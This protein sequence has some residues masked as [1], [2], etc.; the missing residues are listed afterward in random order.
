MQACALAV[1]VTAQTQPAFHDVA[2][3]SSLAAGC[4][5]TQSSC[6]AG[7]NDPLRGPPALALDG[8][9]PVTVNEVLYCTHTNTG[10]GEWWQVDLGRR[11]SIGNVTIVGRTRQ[12]NQ[13]DNLQVLLKDCDH[14]ETTACGG[15]DARYGTF[16]LNFH[17]FD[18]FEL[19]L[20]GHTQPSGAALS[21]LRLKWADMVLI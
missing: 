5:A 7:C 18:R 14:C 17:R 3:S 20:R 10:V 9:V 13:G 1:I 11:R 6:F 16:R 4:T 21:C 19:D 8:R 2:D 12:T 15:D